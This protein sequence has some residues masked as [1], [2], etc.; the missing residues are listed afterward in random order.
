[1]SGCRSNRPDTGWKFDNS[2]ARL[3]EAFY[4][5]LNPVPVRTPQLAVFNAPL[6]QLLGLNPDALTGDAG[7]AVFSGNCIPEGADPLVNVVPTAYVN[8]WIWGF[9]PISTSSSMD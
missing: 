4:V 2:Y 6:A 7:V 1:M 8:R 9:D 3:P 5:R